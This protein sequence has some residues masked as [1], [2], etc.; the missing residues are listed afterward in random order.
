MKGKIAIFLLC[1][2]LG[3]YTFGQQTLFFENGRLVDSVL[4]TVPNRN[5]VNTEE[6]IEV[7]YDFSSAII[8]NDN[9]FPGHYLWKIEGFGLNNISGTPS[10]LLRIDQFGI[11]EGKTC[12]IEIVETTYKDFEYVL[13]PARH[14]LVDNGDETYTKDNVK[15]IDSAIAIYPEKIVQEESIQKYRGKGILNVSVSPIQYNA[16]T[17]KTRVFTHI[18]YVVSFTDR[19]GQARIPSKVG[20][21]LT[22]SISTDDNFLL[23]TL[24]NNSK[25]GRQK[26]GSSAQ[27]SQQDYLIISVPKYETAIQQFAEWKKLMGFNVH[28]IVKSSWTTAT[29]KSEVQKFYAEN[30]HFYFLLIVGDHED[31]PAVSASYGHKPHITDHPYACMDGDDDYVPDVYMGRLSVSSLSEANVVVNKIINYEK[32]PITT[33]SFYNTGVNCAYF[34]DNGKDYGE[35]IDGYA[36]RRFAQTS[37]DIRNYLLTKGKTIKRIYKTENTVIPTNWNKQWFS[38]GEPIP[39]ELRKP[40]FAWSGNATDIINAINAGAFYVFHRDHGNPTCW[41]DP[42]FTQS[43]IGKLSNGN[44]LP[45]V[46]SINCQTGQFNGKTC[47]TETF[48]RKSNGG[49]VAIY[50][51]T[52]NSL[53]G[54]NDVLAGGMFDA[55]WPDPGLRIVLPGKTSGGQTPAPTYRLGQILNQGMERMSEVYGSTN[56]DGRYTRE[57]F[58]CFG[59]PSMRIYTETP[60]AFSGVNFNRG[61]ANITVSLTN[62]EKA[63]ITFYNLIN[64]KVTSYV[65]SNAVYDTK[66]PNYVTVCVSGHNKIPYISYGLTPADNIYIQNETLSGSKTYIGKNI[67]IGENVTTSKTQG[68]V[69]IKTGATV[70]LYGKDVQIQPGTTI[71]LGANVNIITQ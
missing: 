19:L 26:A 15:P 64:G 36:D 50:G 7:T 56:E 69:V 11:P 60:T 57:I 3:H 54:Y 47:F 43:D 23:N 42:R 24:L 20:D 29:V 5:V 41:G 27:L 53:S 46:F 58:H 33:A 22:H 31:V 49:S 38:N 66:T 2:F 16:S 70:N 10:T 59:D 44:K 62:G 52:E 32:S 9:L 37:E 13:S 61:T 65:G 40:G 18:K 8:I 39:A 55:I 51:A 12:Q 45:V 63:T 17:G 6:G 30:A 28:T 68:A 14:P 34:Q 4:P 1:F 71:E 35:A 25:E 48:L 21:T 67:K